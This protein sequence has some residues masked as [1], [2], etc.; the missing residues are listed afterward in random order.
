MK[1]FRSLLFTIA[2]L[3][4]LAAFS[5]ANASAS[6]NPEMF[7]EYFRS[8]EEIKSELIHSDRL[9]YIKKNMYENLH[10]APGTSMLAT[11]HEIYEL[12]DGYKAEFGSDGNVY[13]ITGS[14]RVQ[15]TDSST[16]LSKLGKQSRSDSADPYIIVLINDDAVLLGGKTAAFE[17][18]DSWNGTDGN[19]LLF[20]CFENGRLLK[21]G[22]LHGLFETDENGIFDFDR[23]TLKQDL[24]EYVRTN[25]KTVVN[26]SP[27]NTTGYIS[28]DSYE[29]IKDLQGKQFI[30]AFY[31]P[32]IDL[33]F[34]LN[35]T[36][37]LN[38]PIAGAV[39]KNLDELKT[40]FKGHFVTTKSGKKK[41]YCEQ[42]YSRRPITDQT[43]GIHIR[44][45]V[46]DCFWVGKVSSEFIPNTLS[47][48]EIFEN[49]FWR[50][51]LKYDTV[52]I[53]KKNFYLKNTAALIDGEIYFFDSKGRVITSKWIPSDRLP[54]S[55]F[56]TDCAEKFYDI[57]KKAGDIYVNADGHMLKNVWK[58]RNGQWVHLD[59]DGHMM[60]NTWTL[61]KNGKTHQW[62]DQNGHVDRTRSAA[63][64]DL[65][66]KLAEL[67][68]TLDPKTKVGICSVFADY[69]VKY[70][71][72]SNAKAKSY[73]C[74]WDRIRVGD[75]IEYNYL[76]TEGHAA[77]IMEKTE[78][79]IGFAD[80]NAGED[81]Q[82]YFMVHGLSREMLEEYAE[83]G[84]LKLT[85]YYK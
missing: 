8:H 16:D 66:C 29:N 83:R 30:S 38:I 6:E 12:R 52:T 37:S 17:I 4:C 81:R 7:R 75:R 18:E 44:G 35:R 42:Y 39:G 84:D 14:G 54:D 45:L 73:S 72:G 63:E 10:W 78:N 11:D 79:Y 69:L 60:C 36:A 47:G 68:K 67:S 50:S 71:F 82:P 15:L 24:L 43:Y 56:E 65:Y 33:D 80:S 2:L 53:K 64:Y 22:R 77:I 57:P 28:H 55:Y 19:Q 40:T 25:P 23:S 41:Y 3:I 27:D 48:K 85:T 13:A 62:L 70:L 1:S 20:L 49:V 61:S 31:E 5:A 59:A 26:R 51:S 76:Y 21:N 58:K 34:V 46:F 74:N 32:Y 9:S